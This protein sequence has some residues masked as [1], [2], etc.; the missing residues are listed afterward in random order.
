M[1]GLSPALLAPMALIVVSFLT[2]HAITK[3][4]RPDLDPFLFL[5][6]VY[7][8]ALATSAVAAVW[9]GQT[10]VPGGQ[11]APRGFDWV[12]A[13]LLGLAL[14]GIEAGFILAYRAGWNVSVAPTVA[15]VL[16]GLLL[17]PL[18]L[19]VF[20]EKLSS[21]NLAGLGLAVLGLTLMLHRSA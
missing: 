16:V 9:P 5:M 2:Y 7:A 18:A 1:T 4:L 11:S 12:L 13:V 21:I 14:V 17:V 15:N 10:P 19:L 20:R 3:A 6:A 8:I